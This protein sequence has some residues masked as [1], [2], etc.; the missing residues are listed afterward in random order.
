MIRAFCAFLDFCYLVRQ[1]MINDDTLTSIQ[2]ALTKFHHYR[3]IFQITG[4]RNMDAGFNLPRQHSLSHYPQLIRLFGAPNGLCSSITESKHIGVVKNPYRDS[5]R[6][7][8]LGQMLITNQRMD[9]LAAARVDFESRGMLRGPVLIDAC[10]R[11]GA[12]GKL[13]LTCVLKTIEWHPDDPI[14]TAPDNFSVSSVHGVYGGD[15]DD[16]RHSGGGGGGSNDGSEADDTQGHVSHVYL[17]SRRGTFF[18]H[19]PYLD[20]LPSLTEGNYPT[21]AAELA[22][23]FHQHN[24]LDLIRRF[25]FDQIHM[26]DLDAPAGSDVPLEQCPLFDSKISV[27]HSMVAVFYSPSD[28][29]GLHGMRRETIRATPCWRKRTMRYDTVFV[30]RDPAR[31]GLRGF[32]VVRVLAIFAFHWMDEYYPCALVHWFTHMGD[33]RDE[34]MD[35]WVV[36]PDSDADGSPAVGVIHLDSVLRAVHLMPVFGDR[37]MPIDLTADRSL[38]VF[39]SFY[40]NKYIDYHAF[41]L[42]S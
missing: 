28:P 32:D 23:T 34:V 33:E 2:A 16:D 17:P 39:Q 9:K 42:A 21:S 24:F 6:C 41:E 13:V 36:Q 15:N 20:S 7:D 19:F 30:E 35:M 27:Y 22:L 18:F 40:I 12:L 8:P 1:E 25:L 4:V 31:V 37:M 11:A 5:N 3:D 26:H 14:N 10:A 29:S 38:D